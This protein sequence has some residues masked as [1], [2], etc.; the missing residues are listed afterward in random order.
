MPGNK[1]NEFVMKADKAS[2][3]AQYMALFR[4]LETAR[5]PDDRIFTDPDAIRFLDPVLQFAARLSS[6]P[7][8]RMLIEQYIQR[9][10]PGALSSGVA[11]TKYIDDILF[12]A[13]ASGLRQVIILGAGFDT[14]ALRLDFLQAVP[15][16]EIDHPNTSYKKLKI[17][18]DALHGNISYLQ[19]DF[20]VQ[21]LTQLSEKKSINYNIPTAIIWEGVTNYLSADA[22]DST[23]AWIRK[24]ARGSYVIFTYVHADLLT[25]PD[26][27]FGG[28]KLLKGL[29]EIDERWTFGFR[30][31]QLS[32]Y[33][34]KYNLELMED[35]G[36][37]E[38][39]ARYLPQRNQRGYEFYRTAY[40][41]SY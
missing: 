36:A 18:A 31:G 2:K 4:A 17:L 37:E 25:S 38:Y 8:L 9:K 32:A 5:T 29:A 40:A 28:K 35:L 19:I 21:S 27:F 33:L 20:N 41:V 16:I 22:V 3:T 26:K 10:V 14:R 6:L 23:F 7:P 30:P 12:K 15:V 1:L 24:F 39:R 34:T 11:R 13:M